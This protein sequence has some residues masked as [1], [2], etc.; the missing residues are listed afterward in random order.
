[1]TED[2]PYESTLTG[3]GGAQFSLAEGARAHEL[4]E[5]GV[6]RAEFS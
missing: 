6:S 4:L 5:S 1:M 3:R 2:G